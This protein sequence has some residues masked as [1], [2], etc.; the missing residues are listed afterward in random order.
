[1]PVE[2]DT[3]EILDPVDI[4]PKLPNDFDE[5]LASK[6]WQERKAVLETLN[7]ILSKSPKLADNPDYRGLI[8]KLIK[9]RPYLFS[10]FFFNYYYALDTCI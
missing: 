8:E 7:D 2:I 5:L 9:V 4:M 1:M 6:K 10:H 3:W